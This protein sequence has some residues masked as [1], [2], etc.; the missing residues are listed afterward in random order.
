MGPID[1]IVNVQITATTATPQ[2]PNFGTPAILAYHT[3][4]PDL[5]R[6]YSNLG[7]MTSDGFVATE[8]AMIMATAILSQSPTVPTFKVIRA[9]GLVQQTFTVTYAAGDLKVGQAVGFEV[10]GVNRTVT[11]CYHTVTGAD[12]LITL[13]AAIAAFV[14][15]G[16]TIATDGISKVTLTV[17]ASGNVVY[18]QGQNGGTYLDTTP[19]ATP[20]TDLTAALLVDSSWYGFTGEHQDAT[21]ILAGSVWAESNKR[22]HCYTTADTNNLGAGTGIGAALKTAGY[23]YS[24]GMFSGTPAA[25]GATALEAQRFTAVPGSDTWAFKQLAG[26][27]ADS[28]SPTQITN[29]QGN[30]L[31]YYLANVAGVNITQTGVCASGVYADIRR[32]IDALAAQIQ[33]QVYTLLVTLPKL[34]YDPSGLGMIAAEV[35]SALAQFTASASN[36]AALL[37]NDPG[38]QWSVS[39]PAMSTVTSI[40]RSTR[41]LRNVQFVAYAQNAVQTVMITG[42]V[43]I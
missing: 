36:P 34:P 7:G 37:R 15:N 25:Y 23:N 16:C 10:V 40:D 26:V 38:Y 11:S 14:P 12:T 6:T 8:P 4:Y 31:N 32:G 27:T 18:F 9:T 22:F 1:S 13:A 20:G 41:T 3:H 17:T 21:N 2:L 24:F 35:K 42:T 33:I 5:I 28:L 39:V 30:N 43:N 29:L 19:T